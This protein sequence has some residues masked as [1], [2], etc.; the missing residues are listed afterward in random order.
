LRSGRAH[1]ARNVAF[2][3][4]L[5]DALPPKIEGSGDIRAKVATWGAI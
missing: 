2:M 4:A 1:A 3:D 5:D